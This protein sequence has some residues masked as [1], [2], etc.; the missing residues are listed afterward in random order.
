MPSEMHNK[1]VIIV[2]VG[3]WAEHKARALYPGRQSYKN[4]P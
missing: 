2:F 3:R 4:E 1:R